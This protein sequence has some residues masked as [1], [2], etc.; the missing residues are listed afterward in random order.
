MNY[1]YRPSV[2]DYGW[3]FYHGG[4]M[5][6]LLWGLLVCTVLFQG[7]GAGTDSQDNALVISEPRIVKDINPGMAPSEIK[8]LIAFKGK[9]YFFAYEDFSTGDQQLWVSDGSLDGTYEITNEPNE[10]FTFNRLR[11]MVAT[12]SAI[13]FNIDPE[14]LWISDGTTDGTPVF[15]SNEADGL[16]NFQNLT[17][18][19]DT[20]YFSVRETQLW[21]TDGTFAGTALVKEFTPDVSAHLENFT[22]VGTRLFFKANDGVHGDELW[23]SDG[24]PEGTK[25]VK[26]ISPAVDSSHPTNLRPVGDVLYFSADDGVNG[27]EPWRSDGTL[28][29]TWMIS[30][31]ND[32]DWNASA[33]GFIKFE[34]RIYFNAFVE[35]VGYRL[36]STDPLA[37]SVTMLSN[38]AVAVVTPPCSGIL[39]LFGEDLDHGYELWRTD[40]TEDGTVL[41]K[42]IFPGPIDSTP[43]NM[44]CFQDKLYF[45][46]YNPDFIGEELMVSDGTTDGTYLL[47][48]I[49]PYTAPICDDGDSDPDAFTI[50]NDKQLFFVAEDCDN[51]RELWVIEALPAN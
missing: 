8:L 51:G 10:N 48:D 25:L 33:G 11:Q 38:D 35:G 20:L 1:D 21:K 45:S 32:G 49:E 41:T 6:S 37:S 36:W 50:A 42:D 23:V 39:P 43:Q 44:T 3:L 15:L 26:D 5:K 47:K 19:G 30:D 18:V 40:G 22:A 24:T 28:S 12:D 16:T 9:V 13:Y 34:N 4:R 17:A 46:A 29:G 27:D 14:Y 2:Y 7:C 31:I